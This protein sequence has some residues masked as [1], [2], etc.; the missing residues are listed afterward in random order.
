MHVLADALPNLATFWREKDK[1]AIRINLLE[2]LL[3]Q[4]NSSGLSTCAY[5]LLIRLSEWYLPMFDKLYLADICL[6]LSRALM[7]GDDR[8]PLPP[9]ANKSGRNETNDLLAHCAYD[10]IALCVDACMFAQGDDDHWLQQRYGLNRVEVW[11]I[12][13][14]S[15]AHWYMRRPQEF[16]PIID[17]YPKDGV[18]TEDDYPT[19]VFTSGSALLANQLY[20]TGMLLLLQHKPRFANK[21]S[22]NSPSMSTLWHAHRVCG[23]AIQ[24][25]R[26]S[27][28]DPCLVASLI[29]AGRTATHASQHNAIVS[30][31]ESVQRLTGW[32]VDAYV[33]QLRSEWQLA[34]SS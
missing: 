16:Q 33:N 13:I 31:L 28:W 19:I 4:L 15:F 34:E 10:A 9:L 27:W 6:E 18:L 11:K 14:Q 26:H 1:G 12:L 23:I 2:E 21:P 32:T 5:W 30:T 29:V 3:L 24:N 20:H 25:D 22:Q 7:A 8:I 17:L